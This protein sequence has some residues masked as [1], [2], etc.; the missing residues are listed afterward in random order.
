MY[1]FFKYTITL[2]PEITFLPTTTCCCK[3]YL[4]FFCILKDFFFFN[5][6]VQENAI[7][8]SGSVSVLQEKKI[9][10]TSTHYHIFPL[11]SLWINNNTHIIYW[12]DLI[13]LDWNKCSFLCT[14]LRETEKNLLL[15][16]FPWRCRTILHFMQKMFLQVIQLQIKVSSFHTALEKGYSTCS[17]TWNKWHFPNT[18]HRL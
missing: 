14:G 18:G 3:F 9:S 11:Q 6:Q 16:C 8:T 5:S 1:F 15:I 7:F 4:K 10:L 13:L 12:L 2:K 17:N